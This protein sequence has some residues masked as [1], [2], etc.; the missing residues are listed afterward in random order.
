MRR[1]I[2]Q[3]NAEIIDFAALAQAPDQAIVERFALLT[4][5]SRRPLFD[6][7]IKY[8]A[9]QVGREPQ[10][11]TVRLMSALPGARSKVVAQVC[12]VPVPVASVDSVVP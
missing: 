2:P 7:K 12:F 8:N 1:S 9:C 5:L 10:R 11:L 3:V 4:E 6:Q